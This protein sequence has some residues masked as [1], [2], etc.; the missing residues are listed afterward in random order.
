MTRIKA[1]KKALVNISDWSKAD[2]LIHDLGVFEMTITAAEHEATDQINKI[3]A[4]LE[5]KV[6]QLRAEQ[7][8][9]VDS[10]EQFALFHTKDFGDARSRKLDFGMLGWRSSTAIEIAATTL[11]RIK[12]YFT[13]AEQKACIR[14]GKES[15]DKE[16][17]AKLT[18]E[19][20]A[21]VK[22]RRK[23]K[24][25]FFVEPLITEAA[26]KTGT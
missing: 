8:N 16:A 20:L 17:L 22:A 7:K 24:D 10:L 23:T 2:Q 3:K 19:K 15:V 5:V 13:S 26:D 18:D 21:I 4:D 25:A 12:V 9:L 6:R 11:E 1:E 14:V